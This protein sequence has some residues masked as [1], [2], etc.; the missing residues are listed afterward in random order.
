M[1]KL[2]PG[3]MAL[4]DRPLLV[5]QWGRALDLPGAAGTELEYALGS[6]TDATLSGTDSVLV[7]GSPSKLFPFDGN[8]KVRAECAIPRLQVTAGNMD[9]NFFLGKPGAGNVWNQESENLGNH[10][11]SLPNGNF[12]IY[13]V[14]FIT[15]PAGLWWFWVGVTRS[16]GT[17]TAMGATSKPP[18]FRI[19]AA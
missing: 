2:Y 14:Q 4:A 5:D 3:G 9:I 10:S 7:A 17:M 19:T 12:P 18:W 1:P 15:P 8:T 11:M 6:A 13:C 16:G